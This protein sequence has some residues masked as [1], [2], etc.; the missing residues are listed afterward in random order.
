MNDKAFARSV[1]RDD[2][3]NKRKKCR[4]RTVSALNLQLA[5][6]YAS[7]LGFQ[8]RGFYFFTAFFFAVCLTGFLFVLLVSSSVSESAA[9][10]GYCWTDS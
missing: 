10:N 6:F 8:T 9:L 3:I 5:E 1:N 4:L 2:I 7:R